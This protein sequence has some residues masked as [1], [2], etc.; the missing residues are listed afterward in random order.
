MYLCGLRLQSSIAELYASVEKDKT[1]QYLKLLLFWKE[2]PSINSITSEEIHC[3]SSSMFFSCSPDGTFSS[4]VFSISI[5]SLPPPHP[6]TPLSQ[7]G[8]TCKQQLFSS[9]CAQRRPSHNSFCTMG[10]RQTNHRQRAE[11][12]PHRDR[13]TNSPSTHS[14]VQS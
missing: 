11:T 12:K 3:I 9:S 4:S 14:N 2:H 8:P 5:L 1:K 6:F 13:P 10:R 7:I